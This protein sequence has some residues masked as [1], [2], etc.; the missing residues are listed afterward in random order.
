M[1]RG[2]KASEG[3][4]QSVVSDTCLVA[5]YP[6]RRGYTTFSENRS[7]YRETRN[8]AFDFLQRTSGGHSFVVA[9]T[10]NSP[11]AHETLSATT[12]SL[13]DL[14]ADDH[15]LADTALNADE[16]WEWNSKL[17]AC[18]VATHGLFT[19]GRY[20]GNL[21]ALWTSSRAIEPIDVEILRTASA[22]VELAAA[23]S[24]AWVSS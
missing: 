23:P 3:V 11:F 15:P 2:P 8:G 12:V 14:H 24:G 9:V 5:N 22:I 19:N 17:G 7:A 4:E 16:Y 20:R 10:P 18:S 1:R 13:S 6:N 21:C